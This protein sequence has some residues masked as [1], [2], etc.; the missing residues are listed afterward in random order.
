MQTKAPK[1]DHGACVSENLRIDFV[2]ETADRMSAHVGAFSAC[3][4]AG[5]IKTAMEFWACARLCGQAIS[6]TMQEIEKGRSND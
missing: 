2:C 4:W 6:K 1:P 3:M 5:D